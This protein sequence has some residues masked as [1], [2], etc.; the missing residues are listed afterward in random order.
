MPEPIDINPLRPRKP[1]T[2]LGDPDDLQ[3]LFKPP[4]RDREARI[5]V[6]Q[7]LKANITRGGGLIADVK[8]VPDRLTAVIAGTKRVNKVVQQSPAP[9]TEVPLGTTVMLTV[10]AADKLPI[11]V[12]DAVH[13]ALGGSDTSV[14]QV[15]AKFVASNPSLQGV[16]ARIDDPADLTQS[17]RA[18]VTAAADGNHVGL[19]DRPGETFDDFYRGLVAANLF[20]PETGK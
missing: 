6:G 2:R 17:D 18:L 9:G 13:V 7:N 19:A 4:V 20:N 3:S 11:N 16:L 5:D 10:V 14:A 12:F 15:Y 1:A 8:F